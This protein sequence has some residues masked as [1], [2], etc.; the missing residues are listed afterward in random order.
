MS[1]H[2]NK[3]PMRYAISAL[4]IFSI[5]ISITTQYFYPSITTFVL[6]TLTVGAISFW[7][8]W[9][10]SKYQG[11]QLPKVD[12][13]V[14]SDEHT[15]GKGIDIGEV[16]ALTKGSVPIWVRHIESARDQSRMAIDELTT[17]FS[18]IV[19][20]LSNTI[21]ASREAAGDMAG[22]GEHGMIGVFK[23]S[24]RELGSVI[25][26]L[27]VSMDTKAQM[28][29]QIHELNNYMDDMT[30]MA[31]EVAKIAGQTNLL[32]LNAA[33]EAARAGEQGRGFAVVADEVRALSQLSGETGKNITERVTMMRESMSEAM[34]LTDHSVQTDKESFAESES[35]I[36]NVMEKLQGIVTGL[37]QSSELLQTNSVSIQ[38]EIEEALISLQFQDRISQILSHVVNTQNEFVEQIDSY[39]S[40]RIS[41]LNSRQWI[42]SMRKGYAMEEQHLNHAGGD[43]TG[44]NQSG[45]MTFF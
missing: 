44:N 1:L 23:E 9:Y 4:I 5:T 27:R 28:L 38:S 34:R 42:E 31:V 25:H 6:S 35:S 7:G 40:G 29:N 22:S 19:N 10:L 18:G 26:S 20:D 36:S 2:V 41:E 37:S 8:A 12:N 13:E 17:N 3:K 14:A 45:G 11:D 16:F 21:S 39:E 24:E 30:E 15:I 33:I 32:A 43:V